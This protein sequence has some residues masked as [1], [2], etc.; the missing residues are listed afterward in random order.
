[1]ILLPAKSIIISNEAD[2]LLD[3][4]SRE[5][6]TKLRN[7]IFAKYGYIFEKSWL[8]FYFSKFDWYSA[9]TRNVKLTAS[10]KALVD[11]IVKIEKGKLKK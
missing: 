3:T 4:L 2:P 5:E 1:M 8:G 11:K 9:K 10:E 6:L 7:S